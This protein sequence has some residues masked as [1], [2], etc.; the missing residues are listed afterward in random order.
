MVNSILLNV[1]QFSN[2]L[3]LKLLFENV[4]MKM[5][6]LI[7]RKCLIEKTVL[8]T[9]SVA[10][11]ICGRR[12][13]HPGREW[14]GINRATLRENINRN[15]DVGFLRTHG[16]HPSST[17]YHLSRSV[18]SL[19]SHQEQIGRAANNAASTMT[20][21][22]RCSSSFQIKNSILSHFSTAKIV[23]S[24]SIHIFFVSIFSTIS[25]QIQ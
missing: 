19:I 11:D 10:C 21:M 8:R 15:N 24:K 5:F 6:V 23:S 7:S 13:S 9:K 2:L 22:H 18:T 4:T 25:N 16:V 17:S 1:F 3:N 14:S 12:T 20:L